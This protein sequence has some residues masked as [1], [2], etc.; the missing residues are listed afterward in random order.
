MKP[1]RVR[2]GQRKTLPVAKPRTR[3]RSAIQELRRTQVVALAIVGTPQNVIAARLRLHFVSVSRILSEPENVARVK[4]AHATAF[5]DAQATLR[6]AC[7]RA[8]NTLIDLLEHESGHVRAR[9]AVEILTMAGADAPK[10]FDA[11]T[12]EHATDAELWAL[13]DAHR[14]EKP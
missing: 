3:R 7:L 5:A 1:G 10:R 8:A 13:L 12:L 2:K 11:A 4:A 6:Q 14:R 9:A